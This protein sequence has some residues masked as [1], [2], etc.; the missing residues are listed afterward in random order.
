[1]LFWRIFVAI[2]NWTKMKKIDD[3]NNSIICAKLFRKMRLKRKFTKNK[4]IILS[5]VRKCL[6][7]KNY[8][9]DLSW[10]IIIFRKIRFK[11]KSK[12][13]NCFILSKKILFFGKKRWFVYNLDLWFILIFKLNEKLKREKTVTSATQSERHPVTNS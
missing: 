13:I 7:K 8:Y 2:N 1:M 12:N 10:C 11:G 3:D 5:L 4:I 6:F 9:L